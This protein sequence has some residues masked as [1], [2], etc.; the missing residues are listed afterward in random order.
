M[1]HVFSLVGG[2]LVCSIKEEWQIDHENIVIMGVMTK[3]A[4]CGWYLP[5]IYT[6]TIMNY[7]WITA[8]MVKLIK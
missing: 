3:H 4:N 1:A 8:N 6:S 2:A 5:G 7:G